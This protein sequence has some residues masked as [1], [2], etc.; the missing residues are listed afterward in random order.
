L[1]E[2]GNPISAAECTPEDLRKRRPFCVANYNAL[3]RHLGKAG[4]HAL[5][6]GAVRRM[7]HD[8]G[9]SSKEL[10]LLLW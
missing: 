10:T 9:S 2:A 5:E 8:L 3:K 6:I 7:A 4:A 1:P